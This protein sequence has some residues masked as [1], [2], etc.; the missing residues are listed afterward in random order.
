MLRGETGAARL[1]S[2]VHSSGQGLERNIA[3]ELLIVRAIHHSHAARADQLEDAVVAQHLADGGGVTVI[4][5]DTRLAP[6]ERST[7]R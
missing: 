5:P 4:S 7:R 2:A 3:V 1:R 6:G